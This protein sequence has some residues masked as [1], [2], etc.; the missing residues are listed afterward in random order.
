MFKVPWLRCVACGLWA[1][2]GTTASAFERIQVRCLT[3]LMTI[4]LQFV[5]APTH[6]DRQVR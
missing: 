2:L 4:V 3:Q 6:D 5:F 1:F